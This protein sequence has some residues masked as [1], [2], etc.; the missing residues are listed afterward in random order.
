VENLDVFDTAC[1]KL[2]VSKV[3]GLGIVVAG[4]IVKLPQLLKLV[5]SKSGEGLSLSG[6]ILETA[7]YIITLA[8]NFRLK[9][10]FS[11]YGE[12]A[13]IAV[14]NILI[15]HLILHY[16]GKTPYALAVIGGF[17]ALAIPL[18]SA[19]VVSYRHLQ[20]L[21]GLSIP[22]SL[23]SKVPQIVTNFRNGS[24]GQLSAFTVFNYLAGSAAR[25]F[26]TMTEVNDPVI[27]GGF[28]ASVAL[29]AILALQMVL[30]WNKSSPAPVVKVEEVKGPSTPT[31]S[32]RPKTPKTPKTPTTP[33][34]PTSEK[35]GTKTPRSPGTPS[36]KGRGRKKN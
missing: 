23:A 10:P 19:N 34:T 2:G 12:T 35:A 26:T 29:N 9:F 33:T 21:Q 24:T 11:T 32:M 30:Y 6:Y 20:I 14:Q 4:S 15:L 27:L 5:N 28:V 16:T 1:L 25:V 36:R 22:L 3:L 17:A 18:F 8:Y 31:R 13:F 7:A